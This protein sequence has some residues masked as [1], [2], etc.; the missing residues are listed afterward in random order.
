MAYTFSI[1]MIILKLAPHSKML[2]TLSLS[3]LYPSF[4]CLTSGTL[5]I[6]GELKLARHKVLE[7]AMAPHSSTLA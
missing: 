1:S 2:F 3:S 7:K 4:T 5:G 6:K